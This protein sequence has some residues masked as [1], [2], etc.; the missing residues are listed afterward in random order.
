MKDKHPIHI[1]LTSLHGLSDLEG[2]FARVLVEVVLVLHAPLAEHE[3]HEDGPRQYISLSS[4]LAVCVAKQ[5]PG[6][7]ILS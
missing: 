2:A 5:E 4:S 3:L 1:G 7:N 6:S